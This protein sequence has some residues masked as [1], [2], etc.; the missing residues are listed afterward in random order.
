MRAGGES[1]LS[2]RLIF[3][4]ECTVSVL[5]IDEFARDCRWS[6]NLD[7]NFFLQNEKGIRRRSEGRQQ[8]KR[9]DKRNVR[10]ELLQ[11]PTGRTIIL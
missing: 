9:V 11:G 4:R 1:S 7:I 3:Q 8:K 6:R 10:S 2:L 5:I